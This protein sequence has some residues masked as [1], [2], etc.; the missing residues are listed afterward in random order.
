MEEDLHRVP[1]PFCPEL[2]MPRAYDAGKR[3]ADTREGPTVANALLQPKQGQ[4]IRR[5]LLGWEGQRASS[6]GLF[7]EVED[8]EK[9]REDEKGHTHSRKN[10][11]QWQ[12]A[13]LRNMCRYDLQE[14]LHMQ[15]RTHTTRDTKYYQPAS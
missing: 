12:S 15:T 11:Q 3:E 5:P 8:G 6:K 1:P 4:T 7:E 13:V 14:Y 9:K 2:H 10:Q